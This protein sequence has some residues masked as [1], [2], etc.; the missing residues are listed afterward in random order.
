MYDLMP[1]L[2]EDPHLPNSCHREALIIVVLLDAFERD[3]LVVRESLSLVNLRL[4]T[5][6]TNVFPGCDSLVNLTYSGGHQGF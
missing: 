3:Q 2:A 1:H 4:A 5:D 6:G